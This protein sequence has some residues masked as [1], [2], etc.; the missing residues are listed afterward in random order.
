MQRRARP[1]RKQ[2]VYFAL[3]PMVTACWSY[4]HS[5]DRPCAPCHP[6][7]SSIN[8]RLAA[9]RKADGWTRDSLGCLAGPTAETR[10]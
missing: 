7:V 3:Q 9:S 5:W 4:G 1:T 8:A 10:T 2:L 6:F